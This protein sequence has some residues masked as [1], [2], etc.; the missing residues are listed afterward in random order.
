MS[1]SNEG[2]IRIHLSAREG[3]SS[4]IGGAPAPVSIDPKTAGNSEGIPPDQLRAIRLFFM[5]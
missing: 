5:R 2:G 4:S 1:G 3:G